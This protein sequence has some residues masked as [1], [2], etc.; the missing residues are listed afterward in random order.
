MAGCKDGLLHTRLNLVSMDGYAK[1]A[2]SKK[3]CAFRCYLKR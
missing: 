2:Q 3:F 1:V